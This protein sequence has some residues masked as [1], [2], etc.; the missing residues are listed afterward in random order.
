MKGEADMMQAYE[1]RFAESI[2]RLK[3][4]GEGRE[5]NDAYRQGLV[6]IKQT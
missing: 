4:Y 2:S 5:N 1:A 3:N 6:R